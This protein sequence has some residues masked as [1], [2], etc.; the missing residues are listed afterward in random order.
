MFQD[1]VT[2]SSSRWN[3]ASMG[4]RNWLN[5][6]MP[7]DVIVT[8]QAQRSKTMLRERGML[9]GPIITA[10]E[11]DGEI[12]VERTHNLVWWQKIHNI[13]SVTHS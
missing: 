4:L 13:E 9:R 12:T 8:T 5:E 2:A 3:S 10:M 6:F 11:I 1:C 7:I